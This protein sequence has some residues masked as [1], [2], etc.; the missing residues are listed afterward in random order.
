MLCTEDDVEGL[1]AASAGKIDE[2]ILFY[3]MSRGFSESD[4]KRLILESQFAEV[5]DL[6]DNEE[7]RKRVYTTLAEKLSEV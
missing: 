4:A 7:V 1:H 3:I 2:D 5:I 6:I